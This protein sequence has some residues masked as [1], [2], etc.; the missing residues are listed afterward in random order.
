MAISHK[1]T[2]AW[3]AAASGSVTVSL[4]TH[5]S[6]DLMLVRIA[7]KSSAIA[8]C[9][10]S[11]AT[12]GWAKVGEFHDGTTNSSSGLGS[13]AV[14]VFWKVATGS[15]ETDPTI[16]FSQTVTISAR[17]GVVYQKGA[18]ETWD[19]PVGDGGGFTAATS[20][21][22]TIQSHVAVA[23]A[24]LVDFWY[25]ACDNTTC[26]VPSLSQTGVTYDTVAE[27]PAAALTTTVGDDIAADGG[28]R[29]ATSGTS[30]AAAVVTGTLSSV[31]TGSAWQ[32]RLRLAAAGVTVTPGTASLTT[33][34]FAPTVTTPRLVTP[35]IG[36]LTTTRFTPAVSI[37]IRVTPGLATLT[38]TVFTPT[39][40]ASQHQLVTPG[41]A[42]LTLATQTPTV[43]T[44]RLVTPGLATL[45]LAAQAPTV[46]VGAGLTV[47]PGTASLVTTRFAPTVLT[48]RTATPGTASLSTTPFAPAV[49][50]P[51]LVSPQTASLTTVLFT[52]TVTVTGVTPPRKAGTIWSLPGTGAEW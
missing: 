32:T 23:S 30:S 1:S 3:T 35:G 24:D 34:R 52:P 22:A 10:A 18:G 15:P 20:I 42:T 43:L 11:T 51:R 7:Y 2:G 49:L 9:S 44:P 40:T 29:L 37:G 12:S 13:V 39:V 48:P 50:T 25:A 31:E 47:T 4:P 27:Q 45:T 38:T 19:T 26:T 14:A 36:T 16:D 21:S 5:A 28:Y 41:L 8:T 6:G 17:V 33:T 46:T